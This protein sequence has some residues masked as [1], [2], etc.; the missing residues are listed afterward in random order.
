MSLRS[1]KVPAYCFD[2][3]KISW[4]TPFSFSL[5]GLSEKCG[6]WSPNH[7]AAL[8]KGSCMLFW[9]SRNLP[10]FSPLFFSC[11]NDS[12]SL[13][14]EFAGLIFA[15]TNF[16]LHP[17]LRFFLC[18]LLPALINHT[19]FGYHLDITFS[20]VLSYK[21][22]MS[23]LAFRYVTSS[24]MK[25]S[26][27]TLLFTGALLWHGNALLFTLSSFGWKRE[28]QNLQLNLSDCQ[29]AGYKV[30]PPQ[31]R[32]PVLSLLRRSHRTARA[33]SLRFTLP[34]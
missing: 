21:C 19:L 24:P 26:E 2:W 12:W 1:Q 5:F 16:H 20:K 22:L 6:L 10:H 3:A 14:R 17:L 9:Q 29:V 30:D 32:H 7:V 34:K 15:L 4:P 8:P 27:L 18:N 25:T 33:P 23:L 13:G 11:G 31:L 28:C